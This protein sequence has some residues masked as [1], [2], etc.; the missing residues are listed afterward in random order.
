[1]DTFHIY[2]PFP[3]PDDTDGIKTYNLHNGISDG[4][5]FYF[6]CYAEVFQLIVDKDHVIVGGLR[7]DVF[8]C[9]GKGN[10][11]KVLVYASG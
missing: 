10:I 5:L 2:I 1:M 3:V 7:L 4:L 11:L 9:I 8:Q 6:C